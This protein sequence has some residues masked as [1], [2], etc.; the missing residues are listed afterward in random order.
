MEKS[1]YKTK[2][3]LTLIGSYMM[4]VC[5]FGAFLWLC[6]DGLNNETKL[7]IIPLSICFGVL[8]LVS[9]YY[10]ISIKI[11]RL[12]EDYLYVSYLFLP[13]MKRIALNDIFSIKQDKKK[14]HLGARSKF[15]FYQVK[16][17]IKIKNLNTIK[18]D[19]VG[20]ADF[21]EFYSAYRK[22]KSGREYQN[23][24]IRHKLFLYLLD[25][26][27]GIF[28]LIPFSLLTVSLVY[29]LFSK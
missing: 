4:S 17:Y 29:S 20:K 5:F 22:V 24:G 28:W 26:I 8:L 18:V 13:S 14:T 15:S 25:S 19:M 3:R 16:T 6:F 10:L 12:T 27:D 1:I 11:L 2:P 23:K 7:F 21:E 9:L